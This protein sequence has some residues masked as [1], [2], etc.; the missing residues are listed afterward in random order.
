MLLSRYQYGLRKLAITA[1]VTALLA[2]LIAQPA[3]AA[4]PQQAADDDPGATSYR[5]SCQNGTCN[6]AFDL[7]EY[8]VQSDVPTDMPVKLDI[9][10]GTVPF[11]KGG[12]LEIGDSITL[13][14]PMGSVQ[15][16]NGDFSLHLD[17]DGKLDRFHGK[18]DSVTPKLNLGPNIQIAG[19]FAMEIGY[20][21]GHT[22]DGLSTVLDP[23]RRYLFF[24]LGG[25]LTLST[26]VPGG[27]ND[28]PVAFTIPDGDRM[29]IVVDPQD[30]L[31]YLDGQVTLNQLTDLGLA[32]GTF[33]LTPA[34]MPLLNGVV[35]PTRTTVGV[36]ALLSPDMSKNFLQFSGG[37][38]INGGPLG[39]LLRLEG[40]PL[41]FDGL[42]RADSNGLLL[43]GVA[44]SSLN[45]EKVL[46]TRGE[47]AVYI[48][49][50][51][52]E[53][54]YVQ[55]GG[56]LRVPLVGIEAEIAK[57]IGGGEVS[58]ANST[59]AMLEST[60]NAARSWW[61]STG[62]WMSGIASA[63][64]NGSQATLEA[65]QDAADQ[66]S[67]AIKDGAK[68]IWNT[69]KDGAV[70]AWSGAGAAVGAGAAGAGA[71][72]SAG[73]AGAAAAWDST[74]EGAAKAL[75]GASAAVGAGAAGAGAALDGT[76][77][78]AD[79]AAQQAWRLWCQTTQLCEVAEVVCQ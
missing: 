75:N 61:D 5:V 1:I 72:V 65:V 20:D 67:D 43:G 74:K 78:A 13:S 58:E 71:A 36:A 14:L 50:T 45:P 4:S 48:P 24:D 46:D 56:K 3:L 38:G 11:L 70:K 33:G 21:Y 52:N 40:E 2:S 37:M 34:T 19:P 12:S 18:S 32:L 28:E 17:K 51:G 49:F 22:L 25:G 16:K 23:N 57:Q 60:A 29:S 31:V 63:L 7:G 76:K 39:K 62:M 9:P 41:G 68:T 59:N 30:K 35:L 73:A 44:K 69:T 77:N 27:N 79:C 53:L 66:T 15:F 42:L 55:L 64:A 54:P 6:V 8:E 26:T 47:L 10:K